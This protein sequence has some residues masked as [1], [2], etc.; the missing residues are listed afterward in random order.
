MPIIS[1][2]VLDSLTG[3]DAAGIRVR[4]QRLAPA[5]QPQMVAEAS[6]DDDGRIA[7]EVDT[8]ADAP[9]TR[10]EVVFFSGEY[11]AA[12]QRNDEISSLINE[13]VVRLDLSIVSQRCHVPM[14]IAPHN[15]S[16]WWS[17]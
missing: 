4:C 11:F 16:V 7:I 5:V 1:S 13:V 14:M 15:H 10:Y 6:A 2:H 12:G 8:A 3:R 17:R 9:G